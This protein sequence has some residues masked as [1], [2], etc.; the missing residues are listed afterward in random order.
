MFTQS[1]NILFTEPA[2][3]AV[4]DTEPVGGS[5]TSPPSFNFIFP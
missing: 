5:N 3:P 2:I 4:L 1:F